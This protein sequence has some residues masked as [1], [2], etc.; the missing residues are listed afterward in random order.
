MR[1]VLFLCAAG[2]A[3]AQNAAVDQ[4]FRTAVQEQ[5]RGDFDAAVRDYQ[6]VLQLQPGLFDAQVNLAVAL[7]HL[8]RFDEGIRYYQAALKSQP[9]NTAVRMN[10]ALALY[11]KGDFAAAAEELSSVQKQQ[12]ADPRSAT[13]L[14]DC[15]V[16][17]GQQDK[18]IALLAPLHAAHPGDADMTYVLA[19]AH[20][21]AGEAQLQAKDYK[22]ALAS[23]QTAEHLDSSLPGLYRFL[24]IAKESNGDE[25]GAEAD[26]RKAVG[27]DPKDFQANLHLG[28]VLYN[29]RDLDEARVYIER[30]HEADPSSEFPVYEL[31]LLESAAGNLEAAAANLEKVVQADPNWL[32][33]HVKLA[34]LYYKLKR[35]GDGLKERQI[36]ERLTAA[37]QKQ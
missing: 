25:K 20:L 5:Q 37:Q 27:I 6:R 23:L 11:K 19:D 4:A 34:A 26:L 2:L 30:A 31:A 24:G 21:L 32:E 10:L 3:W 15:Y 35:P 18:A 28:G 22:A 12:P 16:R 1:V 9:A 14:G 13:L 36:V 33:P 17:L 29:R 7:V 8:N